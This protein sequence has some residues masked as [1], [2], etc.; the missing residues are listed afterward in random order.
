MDREVPLLD[1]AGA[2]TGTTVLPGAAFDVS[3]RRDILQRVVRW[4]LAKRQQVRRKLQATVHS[5]AQQYRRFFCSAPCSFVTGRPS[6]NWK[7][8]HALSFA[9][10]CGMS[11][12]RACPS[13]HSSAVQ[14]THKAKTRR[15]VAGGGRKPFNQKGTGRAR[16]GTIRAPHVRFMRFCLHLLHLL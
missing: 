13:W 11:N 4:Q 7:I 6:R 15:E 2:T 14:G 16:Q 5:D 10:C 9:P 3:V 12:C 8:G 1:W